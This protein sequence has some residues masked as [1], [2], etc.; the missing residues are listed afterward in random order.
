MIIG[1]H[2]EGLIYLIHKELLS[3]SIPSDQNLTWE[4]DMNI[5]ITVKKI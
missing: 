2:N 4:K 3:K 1:T 5:K